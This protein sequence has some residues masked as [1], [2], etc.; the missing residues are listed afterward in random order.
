MLAHLV[1]L[2]VLKTPVPK[3]IEPMRLEPAATVP[4]GEQWI[5]ELKWD[6]FRCQASKH[7]NNV[8]LYSRNGNDFTDKFPEIHNAVLRLR[9]DSALID[10][11]IV[12]LTPDGKPCFSKLIDGDRTGCDYYFYAFDLLTLN[13][14]SLAYRRL[15]E[16]KAVL[17][18]LLRGSQVR[19]S[20]SLSTTP[21]KLMKEVAKLGLEGIV[22]KRRDSLYEPGRRSGAWLK[23]KALRQ[24][25][26]YV[27]GYR[28]S[29]DRSFDCL[30]VG[31]HRRDGLHF[32]GRLQ[33]GF[34]KGT[35]SK[36]ALA[37]AD[38]VTRRC[39]FIDLPW[40]TRG[41]WDN[42]IT[43]DD[44]KEFR[45]LRPGLRLRIGFMERESSGLLRHSKAIALTGWE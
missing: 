42:G 43:A 37:F 19:F 18:E 20:A 21:A 34:P 3:F 9:C 11:E 28:P 26:F 14:K 25:E 23:W 16:R 32:V 22:A 30:L 29:H 10:G 41:R 24:D 1:S 44:M 36:L 39:P 40:R 35:R 2:E 7:G 15:E 31:E 5:Y 6:G 8:R 12:A 33:A 45:W 38:F 13:G 17:G 4:K 27:G